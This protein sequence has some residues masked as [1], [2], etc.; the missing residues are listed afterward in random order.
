MAVAARLT[1]LGRFADRATERAYRTAQLP[2]ARA[3]GRLLVLG[4]LSLDAL[5]AVIDLVNYGW[6][7]EG[8]LAF[9]MR[10]SC[11]G[12]S[13]GCWVWLGR[14]TTADQV[15]RVIAAW[16]PPV[17]VFNVLVLGLLP[18]NHL[19]AAAAFAVG[20]VLVYLL[21]L[22]LE[23]CAAIGLLVSA[24]YLA[25]LTASQR[26]DLPR[27]T[28]IDAAAGF[29][30]ANGLGAVTGRR[31]QADRRRQYA[32]GVELAEAAAELR[33]LRGLLPICSFCKQIRDDGG[34]WHRLES[35]IQSRTDARF[36]H[37]ICPGCMA[38]EYGMT[39]DGGE[40]PTVGPR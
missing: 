33:T 29:V 37:G 26:P 19:G 13:V 30:M 21:P 4:I 24:A 25:L 14:T 3:L 38:R 28:L 1:T 39:V 35:Y 12:W 8:W 9:A 40:A 27:H 23:W 31:L 16:V 32:A 11:A 7:R 34:D 20:V 5:F 22:R 18:G 10:V 17:V 6:N 36:T 15:E 2:E